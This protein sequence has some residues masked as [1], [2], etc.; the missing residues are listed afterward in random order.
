MGGRAES[1][2]EGWRG[3]RGIAVVP[4]KR[5]WHSIA[6]TPP[7]ESQYRLVQGYGHQATGC[8]DVWMDAKYSG[9]SDIEHT[10]S[11]TI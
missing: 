2:T 6:T 10:S 5:G 7:R 3:S 11:G 8:L 4:T 1:L 9:V